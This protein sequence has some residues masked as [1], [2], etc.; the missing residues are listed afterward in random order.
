[1]PPGAAGCPEVGWGCPKRGGRV[2]KH[3]AG[4]LRF[5]PR[6]ALAVGPDLNQP[7]TRLTRT[8]WRTAEL[9]EIPRFVWHSA[10][11]MLNEAKPALR[12]SVTL[13]GIDARIQSSRRS[14]SAGVDAPAGP[15]YLNSERS[16]SRAA[17][18]I[19]IAEKDSNARTFRLPSMI[20]S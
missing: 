19:Y 4:C 6:L 2:V 12:E 3:A 17:W 1:M 10:Q 7:P 9:A 13:T 18:L 20:T 14:R 15:G 16:P 11:I 5:I 8:D